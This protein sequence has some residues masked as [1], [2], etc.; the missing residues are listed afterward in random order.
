MFG[1][2]ICDGSGA[3]FGGAGGGGGGRTVL[4]M[5]A[6]MREV[7]VVDDNWKPTRFLGFVRKPNLLLAKQTFEAEADVAF[8]AIE[9]ATMP[10][11]RW[12]RTEGP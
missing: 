9:E 11:A 10:E 7:G 1:S 3:R 8:W 5:V 6:Q 4:C 12:L 2:A